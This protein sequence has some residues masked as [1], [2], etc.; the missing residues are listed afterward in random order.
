MDRRAS[1]ASHLVLQD[2]RVIFLLNQKLCRAIE[3]LSSQLHRNISWDTH[4][5]STVSKRLDRDKDISRTTA[6]DS[7]HRINLVLANFHR[8]TDRA[9]QLFHRF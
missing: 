4:L 3:S 8:N 7:R 2:A 1:L 5:D 9:Q 6:A